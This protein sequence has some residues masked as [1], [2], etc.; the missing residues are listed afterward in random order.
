MFS[1]CLR[2]S[3]MW[4]CTGTYSTYSFIISSFAYSN[5][6]LGLTAFTRMQCID[7]INWKTKS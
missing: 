4:W 3:Q 1:T 6:S 7:D 5:N 2:L